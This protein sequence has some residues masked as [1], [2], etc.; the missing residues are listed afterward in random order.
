[1]DGWESSSP[2]GESGRARFG[3]A[4]AEPWALWIRLQYLGRRQHR[5]D[6]LDDSIMDSLLCLLVV[7]HL[8]D[9]YLQRLHMLTHVAQHDGLCFE[10]RRVWCRD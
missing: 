10:E 6:T 8:E 2:S 5:S 4:G 1:M 7:L 3:S 9:V